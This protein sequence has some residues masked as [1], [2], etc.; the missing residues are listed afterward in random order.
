MTGITAP[1]T[2]SNSLLQEVE[3]DIAAGK[4]IEVIERAKNVRFVSY[5]CRAGASVT[6][7]WFAYLGH[8]YFPSGFS[9][10]FSSAVTLL[11]TGAH[12]HHQVIQCM[13]VIIKEVERRKIQ[14]QTSGQWIGDLQKEV[15]KTIILARVLRLPTPH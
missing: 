10:F 3:K 11:A 2:F 7:P 6:A 15:D 5:I 4:S 9:I 13:N 14:T 1:N 12:E 8:Q